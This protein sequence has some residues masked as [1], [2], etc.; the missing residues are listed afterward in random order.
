MM[1]VGRH[2]GLKHLGV[3]I[4]VR[5]QV[6]LSLLNLNIMSRSKRLPI[7]K[8]HGAARHSEYRRKIKRAI[9][10]KVKDI[11]N[12]ADRESYELPNPKALVNEWDWCDYIFDYRF[13]RPYHGFIW[14]ESEEEY[15]KDRE[16]Y[17]KKLSR[18]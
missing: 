18:K 3:V 17:K 11:L 5:V 4:L 8:D 16:E 15:Y 2:T 10:Q 7:Y 12:L 6:P 14:Y 13:R 9:R 1:K